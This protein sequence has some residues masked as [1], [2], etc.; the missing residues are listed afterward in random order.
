MTKNSHPHPS[1]ILEFAHLF[2]NRDGIMPRSEAKKGTKHSFATKSGCS[3][4]ESMTPILET[5]RHIHF[6]RLTKF[7]K[8]P[9]I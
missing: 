6:T 4:F 5:P 7:N 3:F 9:L 1:L 8:L 2:Y